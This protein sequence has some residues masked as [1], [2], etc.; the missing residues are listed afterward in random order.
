MPSLYAQY[1]PQEDGYAPQTGAQKYPPRAAHIGHIQ[2]PLP[3]HRYPAPQLRPDCRPP[4]DDQKRRAHQHSRL[5]TAHP[6]GAESRRGDE[7]SQQADHSGGQRGENPVKEKAIDRVRGGEGYAYDDGGKHHQQK[8]QAV[9]PLLVLAHYLLAVHLSQIDRAQGGGDSADDNH[10][11]HADAGE[12]SQRSE[13]GEQSG[14][15]ECGNGGGDDDG[16]ISACGHSQL[17]H[18]PFKWCVPAE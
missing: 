13:A 17:P 15:D 8:H 4:Q 11:F 16:D 1:H 10:P 18:K 6:E 9:P 5:Q 3:N 12:H 14:E 7:K 2:Y